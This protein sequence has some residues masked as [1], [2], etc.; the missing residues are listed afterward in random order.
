M[1]VFLL[2]PFAFAPLAS[3]RRLLLGIPLLAEIVFMRPVELRA[4]PHRL[5]LPR[6]AAR[7]YGGR[8]RLRRRSQSPLRARDGAVRDRLDAVL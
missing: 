4:E 6:A 1:I 8:R 2:V 7:G 5:A 3:G